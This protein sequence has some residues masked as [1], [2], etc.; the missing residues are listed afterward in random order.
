MCT[1]GN[2]NYR[3]VY[4]K[5]KVMRVRSYEHSIIQKKRRRMDTHQQRAH[6]APHTTSTLYQP[7]P[8]APS[9]SSPTTPQHDC[10]STPPPSPTA[11]GLPPS[12]RLLQ[13]HSPLRKSYPA[14]AFA[15]SHVQAGYSSHAWQGPTDG[16]NTLDRSSQARKRQTIGCVFVRVRAVR[17]GR[18]LS[19]CTSCRSAG[20][21]PQ[22]VL[23]N[24]VLQ[25][26][27]VRNWVVI[28]EQMTGSFIPRFISTGAI[29]F[30]SQILR[31]IS[32]CA[33]IPLARF[34]FPLEKR[35]A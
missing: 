4:K 10:R 26:N 1:D 9:A 19:R 29:L 13:A 5:T 12:S 15:T 20:Q 34:L 8:Q 2:W 33:W 11:S 24:Q 7:H 6:S 31:A 25:K 32:C 35:V 27:D 18:R 16:R 17:T 22:W 21:Q 14:E 28:N 30:S 23:N 3:R